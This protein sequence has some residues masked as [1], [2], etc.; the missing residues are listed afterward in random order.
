[1]NLFIVDG[2]ME[3][4]KVHIIE[5]E[6]GEYKSPIILKGDVVSQAKQLVSFVMNRKPSK[7]I[8]DKHGFGL[9][10]YDY[11]ERELGKHLSVVFYKDGTLEY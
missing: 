8:F 1:M 3:K 4:S 6:I 11:F 9:A 7:I 10:L 5:A 2:Y